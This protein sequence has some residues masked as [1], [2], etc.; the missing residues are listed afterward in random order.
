MERLP[1][2]FIAW[3]NYTV[4]MSMSSKQSTDSKYQWYS[5]QKYKNQKSCSSY[6]NILQIEESWVKMQRWKHHILDFKIYYRV[7]VTRKHGISTTHRWATEDPE[8]NHTST[9]NWFFTGSPDKHWRMNR[10]T[11]APG[12]TRNP[13]IKYGLLSLTCYKINSNW[14]ERPS[15]LGLRQSLAI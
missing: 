3:K 9:V 5:S 14:M 10:L 13:Q 2:K 7:M 15:F 8:I 1:K 6:G 12:K 4:K 11:N